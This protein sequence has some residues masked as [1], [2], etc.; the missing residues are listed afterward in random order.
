MDLVGK[1]SQGY[2]ERNIPFTRKIKKSRSNLYY[3]W[4]GKYDAAR[5]VII[6]LANQ[7]ETV[8]NEK[9]ELLTQLNHL[10]GN[11]LHTHHLCILLYPF[12]LLFTEVTSQKATRKILRKRKVA[13]LPRKL[14]RKRKLKIRF[15]CNTCPKVFYLTNFQ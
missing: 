15:K 11:W 5:Q 3:Y 13:R 8:T 9:N 1:L 4:I 6:K 10:N 2:T 7:L 12:L 14:T